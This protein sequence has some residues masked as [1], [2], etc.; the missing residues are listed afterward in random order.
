MKKDGGKQSVELIRPL[1]MQKRYHAANVV[2]AL[3]LRTQR[4]LLVKVTVYEVAVL[5]RGDPAHPVNADAARMP[6]HLA[7]HVLRHFVLVT[8]D[9]KVAAASLTP[10]SVKKNVLL[11]FFAHIYT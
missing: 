7:H 4:R 5:L 2:Q 3:H 8:A 11:F 10:I 1:G 6:D 9:W